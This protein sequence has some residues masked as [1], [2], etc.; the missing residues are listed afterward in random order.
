MSYKINFYKNAYVLPFKSSAN[1]G[2][3][4]YV[5]NE[6]GES[7]EDALLERG[8]PNIFNYINGE[9]EGEA[10]FLDGTYVFCGILDSHYGHAITEGISRLWAV[11]ELNAKKIKG[12]IFVGRNERN[13]KTA[14]NMGFNSFLLEHLKSY[15]L[16]VVINIENL[17]KVKELVVPSQEIVFGVKVSN[18]PL[19][20]LRGALNLFDFFDKN[21]DKKKKKI[22]LSRSRLCGE[23]NMIN[24]I[25]LEVKLRGAG[26]EIIYPEVLSFSE[27]VKIYSEA[28]VVVGAEGTALLNS[29]FMDNKVKVIS[30]GEYNQRNYLQKCLCASLSQKFFLYE[31]RINKSGW[32]L[33][34]DDFLDFLEELD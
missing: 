22:Y 28:G 12:V 7:V 30:I 25:D 23:R 26:F 32:N 9:V 29:I 13:A 11:D 20:F 16:D 1:S 18:K 3:R 19:C 17:I 4:S 5:L 15:G 8:S 10:R 34:L 33:R 31:Q 6:R 2:I 21:K 14:K 24:E 27:Q